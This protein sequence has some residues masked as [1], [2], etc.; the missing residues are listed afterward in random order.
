MVSV[1]DGLAVGV[2]VSEGT[3]EGVSVGEALAVGERVGESVI[4]GDC[5][6]VGVGVNVEVAGSVNVPVG[7]TDVTAEGTTTVIVG[8]SVGA[9]VARVGVRLTMPVVAT[10]GEFV[11]DGGAGELGELV[12]VLASTTRVTVGR[13]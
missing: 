5:E 9:L 12:A 3:S 6:A 10:A 2:N 7:W 13:A 8:T 4:V 1:D 11:C